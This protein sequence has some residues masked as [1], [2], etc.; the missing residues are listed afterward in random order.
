MGELLGRG[1]Q[2]NKG[3]RRDSGYSSVDGG[4]EGVDF[5]RLGLGIEN[6]FDLLDLGEDNS[7]SDG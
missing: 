5:R 1:E 2:D 3:E 7:E 6:Q 4:N